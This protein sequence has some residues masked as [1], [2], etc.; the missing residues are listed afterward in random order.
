MKKLLWACLERDKRLSY[1][2]LS[3]VPRSDHGQV[4]C[5]RGIN[6][7]EWITIVILMSVRTWLQGIIQWSV[8]LAAWHG[9]E[10]G[11]ANS[12]C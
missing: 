12:R 4:I 5:F 1:I 11:T 8:I 2:N 9:V 3:F 10:F 6:E 7:K